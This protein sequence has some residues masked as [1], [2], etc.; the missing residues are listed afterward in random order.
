MEYSW[1]GNVR[2]LEN[3]IKFAVIKCKQQLTKLEHLPPVFTN[4]TGKRVRKRKL[5]IPRVKDA[6]TRNEGNKVKAAHALGV[7]RATLYRFITEMKDA[8]S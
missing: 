7:S 2:E 4:S 5:S 6:L 8:F 1:P 3:V